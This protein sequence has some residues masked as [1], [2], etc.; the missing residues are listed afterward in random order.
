MGYVENLLITGHIKVDT[1]SR[2][3]LLIVASLVVVTN[4]VV[5][6]YLLKKKRSSFDELLL[7]LAISDLIIGLITITI[8]CLS[9]TLEDISMVQIVG[10]VF[11]SFATDSSLLHVVVITI[12]RFVAVKYPLQHRIK[13]RRKSTRFMILFTTWPLPIIITILKPFIPLSFV[14]RVSG[15]FLIIINIIIFILYCWIIKIALNKSPMIPANS[16]VSRSNSRRKQL[17]L[18]FSSFAIFLA[19][20]VSMFPSMLCIKN[21]CNKEIKW[22]LFMFNCLLDPVVYIS[23]SLMEHCCSFHSRRRK[24]FATSVVNSN[25]LHPI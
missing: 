9:M 4:A 14:F 12:D 20:F 5:L 8:N 22:L 23:A 17:I 21:S 16:N 15:Y 13:R 18:V 1:K 7:S 10:F 2:T 11:L 3:M 25:K 19:F 24:Q 6:G